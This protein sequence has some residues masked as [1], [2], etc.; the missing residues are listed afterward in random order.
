[1]KCFYTNP[2]REH[3][4]KEMHL[5]ALKHTHHH[6]NPTTNTIHSRIKIRFF[7]YI[8][9][10]VHN[11]HLTKNDLLLQPNPN[12]WPTTLLHHGLSDC[13]FTQGSQAGGRLWW[14]WSSTTF[15]WW[16]FVIR[17][18]RIVKYFVSGKITTYVCLLSICQNQNVY[19]L[20][21]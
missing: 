13:E 14:L 8:T 11:I 9:F 16:N 10:S 15:V 6:N 17:R 12:L 21:T 1:M 18:R 3:I 4:Y 20:N 5:N 2:K 19:I 7:S